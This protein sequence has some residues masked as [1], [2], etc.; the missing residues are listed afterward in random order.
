MQQPNAS[1]NLPE[2]PADAPIKARS[3]YSIIWMFAAIVLS[4]LI[5][6]NFSFGVLSSVRAYVGGE[7][8]WSKAQKDAVFHLQKYAVTRDPQDLRLFRENINVPLGDHTA[9]LEMNTTNPDIQKVRQ[10]FIQ[11]GNNV[12]DVDGMFNLYR[13][14]ARVRFMQRAIRAWESADRHIIQLDEAARSLQREIESPAPRPEDIQADLERVFLINEELTPIENQFVEALSEA[15]RSAYLWLRVIL[16]A[17][18][19]VLLILGTVLSLRILQ[20]RKR[21][22]DRVHHIAF[23]DDLTSLPNRLMLAQRLD[24]ALS[25]HRRASMKLAILYMNLDRF[26]VIND[27]LGHEA[28]DVLLRQVADRL[29]S[30]SREGDTLARVGGDEFVVVM[31]NCWNAA[32]ISACAQRLVEQLSAPY[33]LDQKDC[34]VTLSIGISI[35]PADGSDSQSLL[36]A[37]DV[38]MYRAKEMG[39]NNYQYYL[40]SMNVH[41]LERLELESDL[42][43]ALERG[44]FFLHYQPK[45]EIAS[46]LITGVEA[47]LRWKHPTR[48]LVPP[49]DFIPLAE[50][51]GLIVPIG[52]WVLATA[53]ARTN[54]WQGRGL[55]KLSV[56]VNLSAR[57]FGDS[58]LLE[59]LT[60]IIRASGL[61]P[62][63]LELEITESVVMANGECAV[64]VLDKLKSIGVQIAID[65][66]GTGYSSLAYLKRFPIDTLKVDRSF[67]R[68]IPTDSGDMKITRAIIAMAHG[69]RLKVVAEGVE[70]A[71]QLQFLRSQSCDAVQGYFLYRPLRED[72][73]ADALKANRLAFAT[74][75][76]AHASCG[77]FA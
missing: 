29:R 13:R 15:S 34:H 68:D 46:G 33:L 22:D 53:C 3:P 24:Q 54:I 67:I 35:F 61:N 38:A 23:H 41:T 17:A 20:Q 37:A 70:T 21:A 45:V 71:E 65:D 63:H 6:A 76:H 28:G 10:G 48:G 14:F 43:R 51:T 40:P 69:L 30:Q 39:R 49:L 44:E 16:F 19:P 55:P 42:R 11:G 9:R 57:Q 59:K 73:V 25:R 2:W 12:D 4:L 27:S 58:M 52:E 36:K 7:S 64:A 77:T 60:R 72:E 50:E 75:A 1:Q 32:D 8:R 5:L 47:L 74:S 66:F 26:K 62:A 56:A 31:E 18:T